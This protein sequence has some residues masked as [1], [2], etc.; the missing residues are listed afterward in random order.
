[1]T[2]FCKIQQTQLFW[3][4]QNSFDLNYSIDILPRK[5]FQVASFEFGT[6]GAVDL[7]INHISHYILAIATAFSQ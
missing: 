3:W 4:A 6:V 1:M 2:Q 7:V 5:S